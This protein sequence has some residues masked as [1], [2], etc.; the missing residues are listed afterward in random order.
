MLGSVVGF[1]EV[2]GAIPVREDLLEVYLFLIILQVLEFVPASPL[3]ELLM[4][5]RE[6]VAVG[7]VFNVVEF[8]ALLDVQVFNMELSVLVA[9]QVAYNVLRLKIHYSVERFFDHSELLK[10]GVHVVIEV[11]L[12]IIIVLKCQ[13]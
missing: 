8:H 2:V 13:S 7:Y 4:E 3:I 10:F 12:M 11:L 6:L 9:W 5:M 1:K